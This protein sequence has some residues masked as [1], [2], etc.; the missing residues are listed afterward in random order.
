MNLIRRIKEF[1]SMEIKSLINRYKTY[2]QQI[3]LEHK[4]IQLANVLRFKWRNKPTPPKEEIL[5][6]ALQ[7]AIQAKLDIIHQIIT[8]PY[9]VAAIL[10]ESEHQKTMK[11]EK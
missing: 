3:I 1:V 10:N 2:H 4:R 7:T 5:A 8:F 9:N 6:E 11:D